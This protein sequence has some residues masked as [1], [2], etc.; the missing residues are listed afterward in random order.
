MPD[1]ISLT[2]SQKWD[3]NT[4]DVVLKGMQMALG[5]PDPEELTAGDEDLP[6]PLAGV[7]HG[8]PT[9]GLKGG[10]QIHTCKSSHSVPY[11]VTVPGDRAFKAVIMVK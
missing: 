1:N 11:N 10:P 6:P 3:H 7:S 4:F 5:L 2:G 9:Y 8:G